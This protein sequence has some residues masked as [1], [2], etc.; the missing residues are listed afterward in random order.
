MLIYANLV[1]TFDIYIAEMNSIIILKTHIS[2]KYVWSTF[3]KPILTNHLEIQTSAKMLSF[4]KDP[5][6][7]DYTLAAIRFSLIKLSFTIVFVFNFEIRRVLLP[8]KSIH[9]NVPL[10]SIYLSVCE[11]VLWKTLSVR[12]VRLNFTLHS[13]TISQMLLRTLHP[14]RTDIFPLV[15]QNYHSS[16]HTYTQSITTVPPL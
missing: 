9:N 5:H 3:W 12:F 2:M 13:R 6:N 11:S 14:G 15:T 1:F 4:S 10:L 7:T 16:Y 8:S